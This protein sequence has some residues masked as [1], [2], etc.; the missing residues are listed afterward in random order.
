MLFNADDTT[1]NCQSVDL[2]QSAPSG[3][4]QYVRIHLSK[5]EFM[6]SKNKFLVALLAVTVASAIGFA[7]NA[8]A[9]A[10][11][12]LTYEEAWQR[13]KALLDKEGAYG[14]GINPNVRHTRGAACMKQYGYKL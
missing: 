8:S 7:D 4:G 14:T 3:Y 11:K 13:C 10:K 9:A 5:E 6:M 1:A 2:G 12:K